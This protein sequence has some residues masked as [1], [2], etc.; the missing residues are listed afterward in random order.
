MPL[1]SQTFDQLI[2]FTRTSSATFV[3]SNGLIQNTPASANL[4]LW[5]QEFD[6]AAWTKTAATVT[7]NSTTA[8]DGT[9][10]AD[11]LVETTAGGTGHWAFQ[12]PTTTAAAHTFSV[13]MKGAGRTW[14]LLRIRDSS[15]NDRYAWFNL[16]TGVVGTVQANLTAS[17]SSAGGGWYR[18]SITVS[19]ALAGSNPCVVGS[20]NA[21]NSFSYTGDGTSGIFLW[22]ARLETGSTATTYTRNVGGRFPARFDYDPVTLAPRGLLIEE[23]RTNLLT[24][25]QD[26]ANAAWSNSGLLAFGSGSSANATAAPDGTVT[27]DLLTEDTSTAGH[28]VFRQFILAANTA[29]S[30]SFFVKRASGTRNIFVI[31]QVGVD[32]LYCRINLSDGS[33]IQ[34]GVSGTGTGLSVSVQNFGNSFYR[35]AIAGVVSTTGVNPFCQLYLNN[36][37]TADG[38]APPSYTGDGTSGIYIWGAQAEAGTFATSYIPTVASQVTRTADQASIVAPNFAPWYNAAAGSFVVEYSQGSQTAVRVLA[39]TTDGTLANRV[40]AY[41]DGSGDLTSK[42][43]Y[44]VTTAGVTQANIVFADTSFDA[45]HKMAIA[46]ATNDFA[47]SVDGAVSLT[48]T[49]GTVPTVSQLSI[50]SAPT[51]IAYLN[52]HIRRITYY[53]VRLPNATLQSLTA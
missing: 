33:I 9:A 49:A 30:F 28:R 21:D 53:P 42:P 13:Y 20:A 48:D 23:Q 46:Y 17:I 18:C 51:G 40:G 34:Q 1:V 22:G 4:L 32:L 39:I 7:A 16:A 47:G 25:S 50:G 12:S 29:C 44:V 41:A 45:I 24:Y 8:P 26:F 31:V 52:G 11:T 15:V 19:A 37:S 10:T 38:S 36:T 35:V 27:A 14:G 2:D 3:G 43:N 5:T 6:T